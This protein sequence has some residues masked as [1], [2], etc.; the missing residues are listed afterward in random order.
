MAAE[1]QLFN[2]AGTLVVT[3]PAPEF[4]GLKPEIILWKERY[5]LLKGDQYVESLPYKLCG[6]KL[7]SLGC[8]E[9]EMPM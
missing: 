5:F 1:I 2:R 8:C 9:G 6:D 4:D 3:L 7:V